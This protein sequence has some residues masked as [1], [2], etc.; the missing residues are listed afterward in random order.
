MLDDWLGILALGAEIML[1]FLAEELVLEGVEAGVEFAGVA[2][3]RELGWGEFELG[4]EE[5]GVGAVAH[6]SMLFHR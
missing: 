2:L 1:V 4:G 5:V 3:L 6:F